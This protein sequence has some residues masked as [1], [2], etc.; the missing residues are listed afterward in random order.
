M[1]TLQYRYYWIQKRA[2]S[3][4]LDQST[5]MRF[6]LVLDAASSIPLHRQIYDEWGQG[7][8]AGRFRRGEQV[9]STREL[10]STLAVS[11]ATITAAYDQLIAEGYLDAARGSG[12]YICHQLPDDLRRAKLTPASRREDLPVRLSR[13]GGG[14]QERYC[15][16]PKSP[17]VINFS[18]WRPDLG[19][20]PF[21]I[22]HKLLRRQL[23]QPNPVVFDYAGRSTGF[24]PLR[25]EIAA[26]VAR[27]RAV[28]CTA[29][30][31]IVVN[32]TQQRLD[33]SVRL[34]L[35]PGDEMGFANP[36]Y[37]GA[38][39][40]F[41]TNGARLQPISVDADGLVLQQL[42]AGARLGYV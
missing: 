35:P 13:Y 8:L 11:R 40:I 3:A 10:A 36:G 37:Q 42:T 16:Q 30:Q 6:A 39:Q 23:N 24:G 32:G 33:L 21:E 28:R 38:R 41:T 29:D 4:I 20:F 18:Q 34:L 15:E 5:S 27:S 19:Q 25:Q 2:N 26:Y 9:P 31:V 14:L 1:T 7:I 12:T 22:W 17:G